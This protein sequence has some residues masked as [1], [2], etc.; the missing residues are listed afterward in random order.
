[1]RKKTI[2]NM[3]LCVVFSLISISIGPATSHACSCAEPPSVESELERSKAVFS[4]EVLEVKEQKD[5]R[6]YM[7]NKVLFEVTDT[8]KG[9]T[10]SQVIITTGSGGG[11]CGFGFQV[12]QEYLVYASESTMYSDEAELVTIICDRT[13]ELS[14]AQEDLAVLGEGKPPTEQVDLQAELS[15]ESDKDNVI[16]WIIGSIAF[17]VVAFFVWRRFRKNQLKK[18]YL[19]D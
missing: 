1:M 13:T 16:L 12:G 14:S 6:G 10:E 9:V 18:R 17:L 4:G 5:F 7:K 2:M 11:D 8:W 19:G 15:A 3:L